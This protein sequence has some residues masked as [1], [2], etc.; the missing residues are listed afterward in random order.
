MKTLI[1]R[2]WAES[3]VELFSCQEILFH[4]EGN[5]GQAERYLEMV[6]SGEVGGPI[7]HLLTRAVEELPWKQRGAL[8]SRFDLED[9]KWIC[10]S[11]LIG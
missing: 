9:L 4:H 11:I 10:L 8:E 6:S 5:Q 1:R 3:P 7:F 2:F